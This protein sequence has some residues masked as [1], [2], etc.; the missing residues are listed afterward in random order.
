MQ[1]EGT[2]A[3][4]LGME[5]DLPRLAKRV[6]LDEVTLVVHV[7]PVV[8]GM[9]LEVGDE[10]GDIDGCHAVQTARKGCLSARL[11]VVRVVSEAS[12]PDLLDEVAGLVAASL[13]RVEDW[14][15]SGA[16]PGQYHSDVAADAI[17]VERLTGAGVGVVSE[18]SGPHHPDRDIVVVVDPLDG[19]TNAAHGVQWYATSL[20][21]IDRD[22]PLAAVVVDLAHDRWY[23][24]RRGGGAT[25]DGQPVRPAAVTAVD[26]A[27]VGLSGLPPRHLG[28]RQYRAL[29]ASALDLCAVADGTLDGFV[30]CSIDAHGPWDYLGALLV[31][32]EAGA[33][34]TDALDRPLVALD[35]AARRTPVAGCT[36]ALHDALRAAR[37]GF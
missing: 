33:V 34:M 14:G 2:A 35:H 11:P 18:E 9:V 25:R 30:D 5:V 16:R 17:A 32:H 3:G 10:H 8:D 22:G 23:R 28:W 37:A 26:E 19:S 6:G 36:Q 24:A 13:G 15:L 4:L 12:I 31:C 20:C 1:V 7:E 29:G 21:A 27:L